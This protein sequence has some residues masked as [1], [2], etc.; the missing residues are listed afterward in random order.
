MAAEEVAE[1]VAAAEWEDVVVTVEDLETAVDAEAHHG[2]AAHQEEV[3]VL[4][5]ME[6]GDA[7]RRL[8]V[9]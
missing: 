3:T 1:V 2:V 5:A 6:I 4:A 8:V 9:T 7:Q